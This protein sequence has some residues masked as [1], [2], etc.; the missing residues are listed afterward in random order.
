MTTKPFPV[1]CRDCKHSA[2][3]H[4]SAWSLHCTHPVVN[5]ADPWALSASSAG[6]GTDCRGERERKSWFTKCGL[7]GKLWAPKEQMTA[8]LVEHFKMHGPCDPL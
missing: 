8:V 2:P 5:A 7:S 4:N 6:R 3:D 1:L